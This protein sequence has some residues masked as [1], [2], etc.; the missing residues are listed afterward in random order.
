MACVFLD[1]SYLKPLEFLD[2]HVCFFPSDREVFNHYFFWISFLPFIPLFS[3]W[4]L[5]IAYIGPLDCFLTSL[6]SYLH[7]YFSLFFFVPLI[8]LTHSPAFWIHRYFLPFSL[9]YCSTLVCGSPC[10]SPCT[11]SIPSS[12]ATLFRIHQAMIRV[13]REKLTYIHRM[14]F[15]MHLIIKILPSNV[16][17]WWTFTW[18][19]NIFTL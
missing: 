17:L 4:D 1:L 14:G 8:G 9:V 15:P 3:F 13:A 5:Y 6:L 10:L 7:Y 19:T 16:I 18:D 11:I 12:M 2:L